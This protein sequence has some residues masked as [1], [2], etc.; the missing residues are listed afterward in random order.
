VLSP[1][2][3]ITRVPYSIRAEEATIAAL[4]QTVGAGGVATTSLRDLSVTT[5]KLADS[6]VNSAKVANGSLTAADLSLSSF[7]TTFWRTTGNSNTIAGQ[8]FVGTTDARALEFRVNNSPAFRAES[9]GRLSFG[10]TNLDLN[11]FAQ[12]N[13]PASASASLLRLKFPLSASSFGLQ[14]SNPTENWVVGPNIGNWTDNRF[15]VMPQSSN[16]GLII[17]ANGNVGINNAS[18]SSPFAALTVD[19]S[20]GFTTVASPAMYIYQAGT[21]NPDKP[22]IVHS[23]AFPGYGLFYRD[24][25][26]RFLMQSSA[27]D[28]TP[29]LVVDLDSNWVAI[30][31][32][33]NKP[34]YELSVN[35]QIVCEDL[36]IQDSTLWPD[37]V[38]E[39]DYPLQPLEDVEAHIKAHKHLPGVPSAAEIEKDGLSVADMQKR[40]M[41]KIEELTLHLI[42]QNKKLS[43][44][45]ERIRNLEHQLESQ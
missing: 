23:P 39:K 41:E 13:L 31:N 28:S 22:V 2:Q 20:I 9:D 8:H 18:A 15:C 24:E 19:G 35:G 45:E 44:Q 6:A 26:D 30:A 10:A 34:G 21:Q 1:R 11:A 3:P 36:L 14:F 27:S 4:S 5:A 17:A 7:N 25:G 32:P 33:V 38:F 37:Y 16:K 43:A 42:A 12:F 29:S 40:M